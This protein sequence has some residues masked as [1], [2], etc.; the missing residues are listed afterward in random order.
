MTFIS[1][2]LKIKR[3]SLPGAG[4][5]LFTKIFI[6]KGTCI[7]EYK[8]KIIKWKEVDV[9]NPYIYYVTR[10]RVI[11]AKTYKRAFGRYANDAEGLFS[12]KGIRNNAEYSEQGA[13]VYIKAIKDILPGSEIFVGYGKEYWDA[14]RFNLRILKQGISDKRKKVY[15]PS[16]KNQIGLSGG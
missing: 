13:K 6:P 15:R 14:I 9:G 8:G 10:K 3:S 16:R 11:D 1:D 4:K 7:A 2:N 12:R 5:G